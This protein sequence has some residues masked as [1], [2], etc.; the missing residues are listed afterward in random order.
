MTIRALQVLHIWGHCQ[1]GR[2][3]FTG[4]AQIIKKPGVTSLLQISAR[5]STASTMPLESILL[6]TT[7]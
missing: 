7:N 2:E 1:S 4:W 3:L 6:N 5:Y